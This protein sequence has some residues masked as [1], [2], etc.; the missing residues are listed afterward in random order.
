MKDVWEHRVKAIKNA[1]SIKGYCIS[2]TCCAGCAF[3]IENTDICL[4][5]RPSSWEIPS[6]GTKE[7]YY[8]N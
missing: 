3:H 5:H 8:N 6:I 7:N 2:R 1:R 4:L